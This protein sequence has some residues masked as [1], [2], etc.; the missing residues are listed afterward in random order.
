MSEVPCV[1]VDGLSASPALDG[2][3][4]VESALPVGSEFLVLGAVAALGGAASCSVLGASVGGASS[5]ACAGLDELGAVGFGADSE[6][7][8]VVSRLSCEAWMLIHPGSRRCG[9]GLR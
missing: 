5:V 6:G 3:A 1:W 2:F 8:S 7:H 4:V 9:G